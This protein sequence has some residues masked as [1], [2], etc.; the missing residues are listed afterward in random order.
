MDTIS[1]RQCARDAWRDTGKIF[2]RIPTWIAIAALALLLANIL[3]LTFWHAHGSRSNV[4]G[5]VKLVTVAGR[6]LVTI[7]LAVL[8][9]QQLMQS[10][11][12]V[13][14]RSIFGK[15][16]RRYMRVSALLALGYSLFAIILIFGGF[17]IL[18]N[19]GIRH[20][21]W[22]ITTLYASAIVCVS[23]FFTA[24]FSLIFCHVALGG[25][26]RWRAAWIDSRGHFWHIALYHVLTGLPLG[27]GVVLLFVIGRLAHHAIA[28]IFVAYLTALAQAVFLPLGIIVGTACSCWLYRHLAATLL[29]QA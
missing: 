6:S 28:P 18:R 22:I 5:L 13:R 1:F 3:P 8:V 15:E 26:M 24:R 9:T 20:A 14:L 7:A 25:K 17:L 11:R 29:E 16:F 27:I 12:E 19:V 10:E 2:F 21:Q 23:V 4:A